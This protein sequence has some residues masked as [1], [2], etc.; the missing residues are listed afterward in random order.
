MSPPPAPRRICTT[1]RCTPISA[2]QLSPPSG[3]TAL[4]PSLH[5]ISPSPAR[6]LPYATRMQPMPRELPFSR[7]LVRKPRPTRVFR[8]AALCSEY[9]HAQAHFGTDASGLDNCPGGVR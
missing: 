7:P 3:E 8:A 5:T 4:T 9:E 2:V 6:V 1:P